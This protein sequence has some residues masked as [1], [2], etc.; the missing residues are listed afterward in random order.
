MS[1][2]TEGPWLL[3]TADAELAYLPSPGGEGILLDRW[4][5]GARWAPPAR[6]AVETQ[7][8][9]TPLAL[10]A[11][12]TRQVQRADLLIERPDGR[13][14][15]RLRLGQV[16]LTREGTRTRLAA[17][18][19]DPGG[20]VLATLFVESDTRH[21]A[22]AQWADI[23]NTSAVPIRLTRAFGGSWELPV[24]PG[25]RI[26]A[27]A[28]AW[29]R[30]FTP[31]T[32]DLPAG[33][34]AIGSRTG[35]TSHLY[36][37]VVTVG[38]RET[39]LPDAGAAFS[40]A[41]AWSG[42]W[43]MTVDAVPFRGRV[44]V[45]AGVDDETGVIMLEPGASFTT[46]R[47]YA[48]RAADPADLPGAWHGFQRT[49]LR[50]DA[51]AHHHPV[52]YNSWYATTFDVRADHQLALAQRAAD[53]GAEVFVVDD[54]WFRGRTSD[55]AGL[56]DWGVDPAKFP[57]GLGPLIDGVRD[58]G[59]RFGIWVEPECVNP[60]SDLFRAN[61]DWVYR[62][63]DRPLV[64][65]RNQ[66]VLDLGRPEVE[67][68][69]ADMLRRLLSEHDITYLK[70]D[71]NRPIGDGGRPGD[72]HG[73]EWSVQHARGYHRL[74]DL[75]RSEF[76]AVTVE[77]CASGGGRVDA[78]VLARSD[79]VWA[80]DETGPRDRLAIQHGFLSA[81]S[82]SWMA[83]W[84]TD[85]PDQLDTEP[86]SF[87]FRFLVAMCG[88]LGVGG[89]LGAWSPTDL[90][91]ARD[92]IAAYREIRPVILDGDVT[93]HGSPAV[94]QYVVQYRLTEP[95][96]GADTVVLLAFS[97][98][99]VRERVRVAG[100]DGS[101]RVR[102]SD[103]TVSAADAAGAGVEIGYRVAPDADLVVLDRVR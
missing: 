7:A 67:A 4:G 47:T 28:G 73:L 86:T 96:G 6:V 77:A 89:D 80:S 78:E 15:A 39:D 81:Y 26:G 31:V 84:A 36:A 45:G 91:T 97:R 98:G 60:D 94:G 70:W 54:G 33:T 5:A 79:V 1:D 34:F 66:H 56:G 44:R 22:V 41:L 12:G 72:P 99:G 50:R 3:R 103:V 63:G 32:V 46:P 95:D 87:A 17:E 58:L 82:A 37:P 55:A 48:I 57:E 40:V 52:V 10:T 69:V 9:V 18:H 16:R 49:V 8:D 62:A 13:T 59:M 21:G 83:S 24:G 74:L 71:M 93:R 101:Y 29:S 68:F 51:S 90:T 100:L 30:E 65:V 85:E 64:T 43:S 38:A 92:L 102:S 23:V 20:G 61:P 19:A 42:S 11:A 88:V 53:L 25:A 75:I 27:L 14:G 76:P 35:L 2:D